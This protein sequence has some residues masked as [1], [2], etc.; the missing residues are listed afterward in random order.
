MFFLLSFGVYLHHFLKYARIVYTSIGG[1]YLDLW[2]GCA[3][4]ALKLMMIN[5]STG[6]MQ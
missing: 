4:R 2:Q 1:S 3:W 5:S 6:L